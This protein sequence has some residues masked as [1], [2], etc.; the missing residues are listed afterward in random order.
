[1]QLT[2]LYY[3]SLLIAIYVSGRFEQRWLGVRAL[4]RQRGGTLYMLSTFLSLPDRYLILAAT[5]ITLALCWKL[6]LVYA[7]A[8]LLELVHD[9]IANYWFII[10]IKC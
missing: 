6:K 4:W 2:P 5:L 7:L 8:A 1:M 9:V 10:T 3:A